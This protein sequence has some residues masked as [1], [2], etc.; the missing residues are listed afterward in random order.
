MDN[1]LLAKLNKL[2]F[3]VSIDAIC[4]EVNDI[5]IR[6]NIIIDTGCMYSNIPLRSL[7]YTAKE[8]EE[9]KRKDIE[10]YRK[11]LIKASTSHGVETGND[12]GKR[13]SEMSDEE[14]MQSTAVGFKHLLQ[15]VRLGTMMFN[16]LPVKLNYDR[17]SSMLLGMNV[18]RNF[19]IF[20]GDSLINDYDHD[21]E[22][23]D[24]ILVASPKYVDDKEELYSEIYKYF[25]LKIEKNA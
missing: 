16:N 15:N 1:I 7:C 25:N 2:S 17:T 4:C 6:G 22:K 19:E 14:I 21:I 9:F 12:R 23:G 11:G 8:C 3:R 24:H 20:T 5:S 13:V 10:S 18:L